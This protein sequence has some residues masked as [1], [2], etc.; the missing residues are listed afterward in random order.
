[1]TQVRLRKATPTAAASTGETTVKTNSR[2]RFGHSNRLDT[3]NDASEA[4]PQLLAQ[5]IKIISLVG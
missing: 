5:S 4:W 3:H 1:M 2:R